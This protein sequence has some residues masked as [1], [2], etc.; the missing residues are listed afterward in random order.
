MRHLLD[1]RVLFFGG[2]GGVG[3]T[4]CS[5]ALSLAASRA[6]RR[7]LL[8]ST[9]PAHS[10]SDIFGRPFG[11]DECEV[12]P[13]LWG[14]EIDEEA[15]ARR[16]LDEAKERLA[17]LFSPRVLREAARQIELAASMPGVTDVAL[18]ER[19]ATIVLSRLEAYDLV[20]FDNAP[21][22]HALRLLRM[23]ELMTSWVRALT[24]R[25]REAL[26]AVEQASPPVR[27]TASPPVRDTASPP[28]PSGTGVL[29]VRDT[30]SPPVPSGTGVPPVPSGT[31]VPPVGETSSSDP[32]LQSLEARAERLARFRDALTRPGQTAFVLVLVP[33]RLPIEESARAVHLLEETGVRLGGVVVNRVLPEAPADPFL[34]ARKAQEQVY[35][36]EIA[37]RLSAAP[38]VLVPQL[39]RDVYG[40]DSLEEVG[41]HLLNGSLG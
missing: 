41:L 29:P 31:G 22:G 6:G 18:F 10:T 36:D 2:K 4:T 24:L 3:K 1:R 35:L 5:A 23:P 21:T 7:V 40:L 8:V 33:E 39:A 19:M 9:D 28:V 27:D 11:A 17:G 37:R 34:R 14:Q 38:R 26:A 12:L 20:V 25:R 32:V 15:E 30:A 16:Y 13:N